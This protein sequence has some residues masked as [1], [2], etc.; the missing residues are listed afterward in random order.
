MSYTCYQPQA[1][2]FGVLQHSAWGRL[3]GIRGKRGMTVRGTYSSLI[4]LWTYLVRVNASLADP[5]S[6]CAPPHAVNR[7]CRLASDPCVIL[8]NASS[9][10]NIP[11][12]CSLCPL[13]SKR[14]HRS[15]KYGFLVFVDVCFFAYEAPS[16]LIPAFHLL[17]LCYV[18]LD[19]APLKTACQVAPAP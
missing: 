17:S 1:L 15:A 9:H 19:A 12:E 16:L 10:S 8:A 6:S 2:S 3:E 11:Q 14:C 18:Y 5:D 4:G 13:S 7:V